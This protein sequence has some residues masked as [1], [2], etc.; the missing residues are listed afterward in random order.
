MLF[1]VVVTRGVGTVGGSEG[2][3]GGGGMLFVVLVTRGAQFTLGI[4]A[5][6]F[7]CWCAIED[8]R[9]RRCLVVCCDLK[10]VDLKCKKGERGALTPIT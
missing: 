2:F 9:K 10:K 5:M 4:V 7:D 6:S 3:E 8:S 1:V